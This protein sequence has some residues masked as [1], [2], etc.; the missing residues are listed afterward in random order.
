MAAGPAAAW[1]RAA[2][3]GSTP[4]TTPPYPRSHPGHDLADFGGYWKAGQTG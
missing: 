4:G 2:R 3:P 1:A